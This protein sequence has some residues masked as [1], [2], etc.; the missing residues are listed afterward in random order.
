MRFEGFHRQALARAVGDLAAKGVHRLLVTSAGS[1]EGKTSV[2]A[3]LGRTL[4]ES[5]QASVVLVDADAY[6]PTLHRRF[7]LGIEYGLGELLEELYWVNLAH[8][9]PAQFGLGD[10]LELLL[11]QRRSGELRVSDASHTFA[12]R[13]V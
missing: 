5:E 12:V 11:A 4:A 7:G 3:E 1:G 6:N 10:W 13:F 9:T 2:V 8:E